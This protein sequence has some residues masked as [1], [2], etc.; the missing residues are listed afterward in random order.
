MFDI[1]IPT[2]WAAGNFTHALEKYVLYD[3]VH[4]IILI[5]NNRAFRPKDPI[6]NNKKIQIID[7]GTNLFVNPAWNEGVRAAT[8]NLLCIVNDDIVIEESVFELVQQHDLLK[9]HLI[10][11]NLRGYHDNY[12]IDEYI[13][14]QEKIT[15]LNYDRSKPIGSQAWAFGICMFMHKDTYVEIPSLYKVWFGDDY[16]AQHSTE[17]YAINTNKIKG[18]I[19][20]TLKKHNSNSSPIHQRLVL[21][22]KNLIRFKHFHNGEN[23]D[24]PHNI[25]ASS[26]EN[27]T[28]KEIKIL[29]REYSIAKNTPSDIN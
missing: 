15:L 17:V 28:S 10:G 26:Q 27:T 12:K 2:M 4:K 23:W 19:S 13:N 6:F 5:D 14:T 3:C 1:I 25:I 24:I 16:L 18:T 20:E 29:K 8:C 21:D 7:Y 22:C 9:G 11:V